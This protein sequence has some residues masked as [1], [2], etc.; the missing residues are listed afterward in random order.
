[1]MNNVSEGPRVVGLTAYG[2]INQNDM[3]WNCEEQPGP[4]EQSQ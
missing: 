1:M 3:Y 4:G 2:P